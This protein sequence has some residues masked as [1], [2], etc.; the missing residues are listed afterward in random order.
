[1]ALLKQAR[2]V[3]LRF[4]I[5]HGFDMDAFCEKY[6]CTPE[7]F[8]QHVRIIYRHDHEAIL[9]AIRANG[10]RLSR[11]KRGN[12]GNTCTPPPSNLE[13]GKPISLLTEV[14]LSPANHDPSRATQLRLLE[15]TEH[16]QS[17][18][19]IALESQHKQFA[20]EHRDCIRQLR[21]LSEDM[22]QLRLAFHT[23]A[24]EYEAIVN[25]NNRLVLEMNRISQERAEK[26]AILD[27]TRQQIQSLQV[28]NICAYENGTIEPFDGNCTTPLDE[29][30][31]E[32]I[33]SQLLDREE[34]EA[35]RLKDVRVLS[36][37]LAIA[38]NA[39][40]NIEPIFEN[41][42]LEAS[43]QALINVI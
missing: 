43:F 9:D 10:K 36:K 41:D 23:K 30:G 33:Y 11:F 12:R 3:D 18:G 6:S 15:A 25:E 5:R 42:A 34:C 38:K 29:T 26:V 22:E 17:D 40:V 28:V 2:Q 8:T 4:G 1:M 21:N 31:N 16:Q 35:L 13:E 14:Q 27:E 19:I 37:V 20:R 39:S 7:E 32:R 24:A